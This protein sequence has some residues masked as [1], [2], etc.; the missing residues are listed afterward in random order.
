MPDDN[1]A[2]IF[3]Y[4]TGATPLMATSLPVLTFH[5][6][7]D[8]GSVISCPPHVFCRG[9]ARLHTYGYRTAHAS[10][11]SMMAITPCIPRPSPYCSAMACRPPCSS[12]QGL[13]AQS[14]WR[15]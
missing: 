14:H 11:P 9:I 6:L 15:S 10:S 1:G 13:E 7:D 3:T 12:P 5:T 8:Q 2:H 4:R